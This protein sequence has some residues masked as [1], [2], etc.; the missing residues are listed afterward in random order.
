MQVTVI[1]SLFKQADRVQDAQVL[2]NQ[3]ELGQQSANSDALIQKVKS[4]ALTKGAEIKYLTND[5]VIFGISPETLEE[6]EYELEH[7]R[8]SLGE[9]AVGM[10]VDLHQAQKAEEKSQQTKR[11]EFYHP[12]DPFYNK[13]DPQDFKDSDQEVAD[14]VKLDEPTPVHAPTLAE[15]FKAK[16]VLFDTMAQN[17]VQKL[18]PTPE[19]QQAQQQAMAQQAQAQGAAPQG[20][21]QQDGKSD[22]SL[23]EAEM[24]PDMQEALR[25]AGREDSIP[26]KPKVE[27]DASKKEE[28]A[29][30]PAEPKA[31]VVDPNSIE[32]KLAGLLATIKHHAS[33]LAE[34]Q[35][36]NPEAFKAAMKMV[37]STIKLSKHV[38]ENGGKLG[39]VKMPIPKFDLKKFEEDLAKRANVN[40]LPIGTLK[41]GKVKVKDSYTGRVKWRSVRSGLMKDPTGAAISTKTMAEKSKAAE[42]GKKEKKPEAK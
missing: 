32:M 30:E 21:P 23:Q 40:S 27:M 15:E 5:K 6:M 12:E 7:Y 9:C 4:W 42:M 37:D 36:R 38:R 31:K 35:E 16:E 13:K 19:E 18:E 14:K 20:Q 26:Q 33:D 39:D 8:S 34:L 11:I 1:I 41:R 2:N 24:D 22:A 25:L 17:Q 10:G 29:Q 3:G 28:P